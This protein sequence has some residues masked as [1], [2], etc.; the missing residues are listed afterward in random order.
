MARIPPTEFIKADYGKLEKVNGDYFVKT[1]QATS[2]GDFIDSQ[3]PLQVNGDSVHADDIWVEESEM[4]GFSGAITDIFD[5]LHSVISDTTTTNPKHIL[6]HFNRSTVIQT[7]SLGAYTGDF[8]NTKISIVKSDGVEI[9]IVDESTDNTKYSSRRYELPIIGFNAIRIE[10]YTADQVSLSNCYMAKVQAVSSRIQGQSS[11]DDSYEVVSTYR[12]ALNVN[13]AWV[14]RKIVNESFH[15]HDSA[16]TNPTT[17]ITAGDTAVTVDSVVGFTVGDVVKLEEDVDGLGIQEIGVVTITVIAGSVLTFDR[18]ISNEYTTAA[19]IERVVINMAVVGTLANPRV[20]QIDPPLGTVWQ[21][22]RI[23]ISIS[24]GTAMDDGKFGG[25]P[26]LTNGV[27]L[28]ATTAAGRVVT[29][30][31]WKTN[32]D[33]ALDMFDIQYTDKAPS[34]ENGLRGRWTFTKA[35]VVAELD[36]DATPI[37][38]L[39]ILI[40]DDLSDLTSFEIKGQGRVFSP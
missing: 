10:F 2:E 33:M 28:R 38:Q 11:L 20:F 1:I 16:T 31:N 23:I 4:N 35:E 30:G 22:T 14:N 37:Q 19:T 9:V 3:H 15:E 6:M 24:D 12:G 40:Q 36:G 39:E 32:G 17:G 27:S 18:P 26:A 21:F 8:S 7:L 5:N 29:F 25:I 13:N 34:G